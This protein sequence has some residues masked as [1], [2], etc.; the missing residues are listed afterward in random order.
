MIT[1]TVKHCLVAVLATAALASQASAALLAP[2]TSLPADPTVVSAGG[3]VLG[4]AGGA[5]ATPGGDTGVYSTSVIKGDAGNIFGPNA[6]TFTYQFSNTTVA[7][8][9]VFHRL[10]GFR[11]DGF[12]TDVGYVLGTGVTPLTMDRSAGSG[13][14]IGF[15]FDPAIHVSPGETSAR[16]VIHTNAQSFIGGIHVGITDGGTANLAGFAPV[17]PEASTVVGFA[18]LLGLGGLGM[19]RMRRGNKASA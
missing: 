17:V 7:F 8:S 4:T 5:F 12:L 13:G 14:V 6:L 1:R 2:G 15:N 16:L 9:D 3:T 10:T 19:L 18:S 11:F